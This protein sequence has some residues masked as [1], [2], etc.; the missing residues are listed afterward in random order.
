[1]ISVSN[2]VFIGAGAMTTLAPECDIF[3]HQC[4]ISGAVATLDAGVTA[5]FLLVPGLYKGCVAK[6]HN[7]TA[8]STQYLVIKDNSSTTIT[9]DETL[10]KDGNNHANLV[11]LAFGAPVPGPK[12]S[13]KTTLLSDHWLGLVNTFNP[14]SV[15]VEMK[16]LNL[17]TGSTRNFGFQFKGNETVSGGS[18]DI[19]LNNGSWLYYALG[20]YAIDA[21]METS[22]TH[23]HA[24]DEGTYVNNGDESIVRAIGGAFYPPIHT[25]LTPAYRESTDTTD[26]D[27]HLVHASSIT[28][29]VESKL[30][31]YTFTEA[32]GSALPSFAIEMCYAKEG[33]TAT[34]VVDDNTNNSNMYARVFTGNQVNSLAINFEEGQEVKA[35]VDFVT[36]RAFDVPGASASA[37]FDGHIPN[38]GKLQASEL[39]NFGTDAENQPFMFSSGAIKIFGQTFARV[40][41]GNITINNNITPHRFIGNYSREVTSMHV[42]GQRN[43]DA[44][45]TLLITDTK[46]WDELRTETEHSGGVIEVSFVKDSGELL[47]LQLNDYLVQNV[48][49]PLPDDKGAVEVE[50]AVSARSLGTVQY[51]GRWHVLSIGGVATSE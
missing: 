12:D 6:I 14:P 26:P 16:Q 23:I 36:R 21:T 37:T 9:F 4:D 42:P 33:R 3:L 46:V 5:D 20:K 7:G 39:F 50:L 49:V 10:V 29:G 22:A 18:L 31:E 24:T 19:A 32:N 45:F 40:K 30:Y 2:E 15:E 28:D 11:I 44:S 47:K 25:S 51:K 27:F 38:R 35:S 48:T 43:Y 34:E 41:N 8:A 1:M 13:S 17:A